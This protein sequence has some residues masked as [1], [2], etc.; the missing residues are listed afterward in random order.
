VARAAEERNRYVGACW[1]YVTEGC[2]AWP[3]RAQDRYTGPWSAPTRAPILLVNNRFDPATPHQN[4]VAMNRIL[5][6]SR[7]LT[8]N[9]W[10]HTALQSRSACADGAV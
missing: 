1:A 9:G 10:G 7:L 8:V 6:R 5:P 3:A 2:L 4:A